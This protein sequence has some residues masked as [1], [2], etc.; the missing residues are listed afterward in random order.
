MQLNLM[1]EFEI[2]K[3]DTFEQVLQ[4]SSDVFVE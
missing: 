2:T 1:Q 4:G 3:G